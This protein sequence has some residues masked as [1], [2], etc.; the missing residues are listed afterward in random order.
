MTGPPKRL[1]GPESKPEAATRSIAADQVM[2]PKPASDSPSKARAAIR[3]VREELARAV[4]HLECVAC[5][6]TT[7]IDR[8]DLCLECARLVDDAYLDEL[9]HRRAASRRLPPLDSG[10]VDPWMSQ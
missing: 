10:R 1:G 7:A 4:G 6:E 2:E 3:E 8:R 9:D 5:G